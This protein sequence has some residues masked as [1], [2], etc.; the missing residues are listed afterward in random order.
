MT[1]LILNKFKQKIKG[2]IKYLKKYKTEYNLSYNFIC[3]GWKEYIKKNYTIINELSPIYNSQYN[4]HQEILKLVKVDDFLAII[5]QDIFDY[6]LN[7]IEDLIIFYI[8]NEDKMLIKIKS[9]EPLKYSK[10]IELPY[11]SF[12]SENRFLWDKIKK[13]I[14]EDEDINIIILAY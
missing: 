5:L 14:D 2:D 6:H 3:E 7:N 13:V 10:F 12:Y 8:K 9:Y 4:L 11:Y 1:S